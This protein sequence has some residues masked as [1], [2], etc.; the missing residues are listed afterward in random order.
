M[1]TEIMIL[2]AGIGV[3]ILLLVVILILLIIVLKRSSGDL[4]AKAFMAPP[5]VPPVQVPQQ[6]MSQAAPVPGQ[7][8]QGSGVVFCKNCYTQFDSSA[9][10]C[11]KCG[12]PK[13]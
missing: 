11:P 10:F 8:F 5:A 12:T 3:I 9:Q 2:F 6:K 1:Y 13:S 4:P 7:Q